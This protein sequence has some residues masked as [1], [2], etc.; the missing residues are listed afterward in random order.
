MKR[1]SLLVAGV[2]AAAGMPIARAGTPVLG[3][4][5]PLTS[6]QAEVAM[7]LQGGYELALKAA[8]SPIR[9]MVLDDSSKPNQ[10][11]ENVKHLASNPDV[12]ALSG[13]VG[14]PH[15]QAGIPVA[16]AAGLPVVGIRS[17]AQLLRDGKPG[18]YHLRSSFEAELDKL[19]V[20]C[21]GGAMKSLAILY[22]D[23]SFG[24]GSRDQ[25]VKSLK[26]VGVGVAKPVPV[27]RNGSNLA[28][29][30]AECAEQ[31]KRGEATGIALLLLAKPMTAAA[32]QL[33]V[34]HKII[35]P[36]YAMSFSAVRSVASDNVPGLN[37]LGLVSAFPLPR[38]SATPT[39][40]A[41][42]AAC[43]KFNRQDLVESLTAYEG[44]FYGSV[45][46]KTEAY[47]REGVVKRMN[48]GL[49]VHGKDIVMDS[50]R[51]G[52]RYLEIVSKS[53]HDGRLRA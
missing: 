41:Y 36:L 40:Y 33:R 35:M 44:F 39:C 2:A 16:R 20:M 31:V 11:A 7:E 6:V 26:A 13:I 12:I 49:L 21:A 25:L 4:T 9:L 23:D 52:Y 38:A 28:A 27:E 15:A 14:T 18:V 48:A 24:T 34:Q 47:T 53:V 32:I 50:E 1:R 19:A 29:A 30:A 51:V 43:A 37:G 45:I 17:G 8:D 22:S 5:L 46:A 42:R 3:L 10:T